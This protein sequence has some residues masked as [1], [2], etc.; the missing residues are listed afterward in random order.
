VI[1][2]FVIGESHLAL[3]LSTV[4]HARRS[5]VPT[6]TRDVEGL[7]IVGRRITAQHKVVLYTLSNLSS[8]GRL[9]L[10]T[11]YGVVLNTE[12][13]LHFVQ[14]TLFDNQRGLLSVLDI[15]LGFELQS[16]RGW[17][18]LEDDGKLFHNNTARIILRSFIVWVDTLN[19]ALTRRRKCDRKMA[20]ATHPKT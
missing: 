11:G 2:G 10:E 4:R 6:L 20:E 8:N 16:A 19:L 13:D 14:A 17:V 9:D 18:V 7:E 1:V 3:V 5:F 12:D 15:F